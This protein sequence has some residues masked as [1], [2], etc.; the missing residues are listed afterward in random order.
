M[1]NEDL[2][3]RLLQNKDMK[4]LEAEALANVTGGLE[5]QKYNIENPDIIKLEICCVC[6]RDITGLGGCPTC[7]YT[8]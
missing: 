2:K 5:D 1:K 7:Q 3:D 4:A 6:G 8:L